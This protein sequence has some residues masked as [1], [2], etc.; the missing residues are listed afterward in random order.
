MKVGVIYPHQLYERHP[1]LLGVDHVYLIEEPLFFGNDKRWPMR[2]HVQKLVL[3][4]GSMRKFAENLEVDWTYLK[5]S[6]FSGS[7]EALRSLSRDISG[8]KVVRVVDDLLER[9]IEQFARE[10]DIEIEWCDT[11]NFITPPDW[12]H[13]FFAGGKKPFMAKFYEAQRKRMGIM[14]DGDGNPEG[15]KWSFDEENRKKLP[16]KVLLPNEPTSDDIDTEYVEGVASELESEG[17]AMW[18]TVKG[19]RYP[20]TREA[21]LQW[22][23]V[24]LK[25]RFEH[26]GVYE[27]A[28]SKRGNFL[29][30]SALTPMLN[31]GLLNPG[32]VVERVLAFS[33]EGRVPLNSL[34]GFIRQIIGWREFMK[35]MYERSGREMRL[36]NFF[37]SKDNVPAAVYDGD[38]GIYPVDKVVEGLRNNAYSHHIERLMVM[39]SF[40]VL[41]RCKPDSVYR[42]FMEMYVDA[43]D[44]VMVPN[45]YG[46]SQFANGGGFVTKPY[47]SGS[48]YLRKMSDY[49]KGPWEDAWDSLFWAFVD[50]HRDFFASQYRMKMMLSHLT[51]MG[52][53]KLATHHARAA[54][55]RNTLQAGKRWDGGGASIGGTLL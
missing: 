12:G 3:H 42:W 29:F 53:E 10:R 9:R 17:L 14:V 41:M 46:M 54:D 49:P 20:M 52:G 7:V 55:V 37:G 50:D 8:I 48:N 5:A 13:G 38:T 51:K 36:K 2:P 15:G 27:D 22:L 24:F 31:I 25:E 23:E 39:G 21:A 35:L 30:H 43:Y 34:E 28:L 6:E 16:A 45:V 47:V 33:S 11:P 40:F 32:E 19:F 44:W 4:R 26:F 18:G 1:A